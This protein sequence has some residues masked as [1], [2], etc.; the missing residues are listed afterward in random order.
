MIRKITKNIYISGIKESNDF[1]L[2]KSYKISAILNVAYEAIQPS[3]HPEDMITCKIGLIDNGSNQAFLKTLATIMLQSLIDN[4]HTV[5]ITSF[6]GLS[7]A[8]YIAFRYLSEKEHRTMEAV[9]TE[10][11]T[12]Y[13]GIRISPLTYDY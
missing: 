4:G 7:R 11:I 13:P 6:E 5:L 12:Q 9:Y 3:Y 8:P 10:F 2:L 1:F